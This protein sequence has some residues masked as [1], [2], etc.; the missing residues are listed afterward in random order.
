MEEIF[1]ESIVNLIEEILKESNLWEEHER[2]LI[3]CVHERDYTKIVEIFENL[4]GRKLAK[5]VRDYF[6]GNL[7]EENLVPRIKND[8]IVSSF[9][10]EDIARK[11][12]MAYLS[13]EKERKKEKEGSSTQTP[14]PLSSQ[15][16]TFHDRYREPID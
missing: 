12:K 11:L 13:F 1:P 4:P 3:N 14:P 5:I 2:G 16:K 7:P 6:L 8:L 15:E 9:R 10:A